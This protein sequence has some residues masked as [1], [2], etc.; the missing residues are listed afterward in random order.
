MM[1]LALCLDSPLLKSLTPRGLEVQ[2]SSQPKVT[3]VPRQE[4]E[5]CLSLSCLVFPAHLAQ[6]QGGR[7]SLPVWERWTFVQV[8]EVKT[9]KMCFVK[10]ACK[11]KPR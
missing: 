7:V 5:K 8:V 3:P 4:E 10:S 11:Y 9:P 1:C 2:S 6:L